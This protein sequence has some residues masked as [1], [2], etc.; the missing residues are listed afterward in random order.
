M[1][2]GLEKFEQTGKAPA[3]A[4]AIAHA[5][6]MALAHNVASFALA[7]IKDKEREE[8]LA[9]VAAGES[10]SSLDKLLEGL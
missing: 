5:K 1:S 9:D 4:D 6:R 2:P 10:N 3:V 7:T 8:W